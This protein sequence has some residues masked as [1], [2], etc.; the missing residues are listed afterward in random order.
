MHTSKLS[1]RTKRSISKIDKGMYCKLTWD[2]FCA[3]LLSYSELTD[4]SRLR[5]CD[6]E[7]L[8]ELVVS[9]R[10]MVGTTPVYSACLSV[11]RICAYF[12]AQ[13]LKLSQPSSFVKLQALSSFNKLL[14]V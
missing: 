12:Q 6:W 1:Y 13:P 10:S 4:F 9:L 11:T 5:S 7:L 3:M 2:R 8:Q 14:T